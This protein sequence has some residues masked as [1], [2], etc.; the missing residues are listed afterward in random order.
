[1]RPVITADEMR[2]AEQRVWDHDP[3]TDLMGR[4][5]GRVAE[6]AR[7]LAPRGTVLVV[8]GP[9]NNG[10]DGLFAAAQLVASRD[11]LLWLPLSRS[12]EAGLAAA[13]AAGCREVDSL[14]AIRTL[15]DAAL[16]IDAFTG[17][18]SRPGLPD[19]V[20]ELADA[21]VALA[22]PVLSVDLPSGLAADT[23]E[24]HPSFSATRTLT[25]AAPKPCHVIQPAA[26]RCG[27]VV[28]AD[29][30]IEAGDGEA[31]IRLAGS[32]DVAAAWP[33]PDA[34]SDKYSR[35]VVLLDTGSDA[36]P[37]AALLGIAGALHTGAGMV[38]CVGT[39]AKELVLGKYPSVVMG[40]GRCQAAVVGSGWGDADRE[41]FERAL[42]L[43]VPV[44]VD[45]DALGAI[46]DEPLPEGWLLTPHAGELARLLD[47]AR[48][49]VEREPL[50]HA[51]EAAKRTGAAVLL[52]GATQYV[53]E[54]SGRV[55]IA[56]PGPAWTAQAGSGD[57]LA[58]V[59][60]TLLAAGLPAW[61]AAVLGAS[62][63]AMTAASHP[64]PHPPD[65]LAEW[66]GDEIGALHE[67]ARGALN[68]A[69]VISGAPQVGTGDLCA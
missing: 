8:A 4:A 18:S 58:G 50:R 13:R 31:G 21:C 6:A 57:V 38:R 12:H 7:E 30:G 28:V 63:Q 49:H 41:R 27:E 69:R 34:T 23:G 39:G 19:A 37:G 32:G 60:G 1:M 52:K 45:A 68:D 5:A 14:A 53:A 46:G 62:L 43:G 29:I 24:P 54:P 2:A 48:E 44:V 42:G 16:V 51:R 36:Y 55:T 22:V 11:V 33:W 10:G 35:G 47:V 9:G 65:R 40:E 67:K 17:L 64:G 66:F 61:R 56:V 25:F 15:T 20:A 26:G 59:C 3:D